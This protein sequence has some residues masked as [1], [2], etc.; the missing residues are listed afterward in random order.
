MTTLKY[1]KAL[2]EA[3]KKFNGTKYQNEVEKASKAYLAE[4]YSLME[5][6]LSTLPTEPQLLASLL[7]KLKG[8]SV[9]KGIKKALRENK[10][11]TLEQGIATSSLL[12]HILIEARADATY[13]LL[14]P[15]VY[16]RLGSLINV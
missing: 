12:T 1:S 14:L 8:K 15:D 16:A 10:A 11:T 5:R 3:S 13:K 7:E 4:N 2:L 9:E 6:I